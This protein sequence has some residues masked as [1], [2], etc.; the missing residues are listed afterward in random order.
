MSRAKMKK[1]KPINDDPR[2]LTEEEE[3]KIVETLMA[4]FNNQKIT[5][6]N[7]VPIMA[8]AITVAVL[9]LTQSEGGDYEHFLGG[10]AIAADMV[11]DAPEKLRRMQ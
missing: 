10:V 8:K 11:R 6:F 5:P 9:S 7:A 2:R 4:W 3:N 1:R